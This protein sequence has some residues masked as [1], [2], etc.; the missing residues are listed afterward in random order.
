MTVIVST[1]TQATGEFS[2]GAETE[3]ARQMFG[4]SKTKGERGRVSGGSRLQ[5]RESNLNAY[6]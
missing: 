3:T 5:S 4:K 1:E 2:D 6:Y